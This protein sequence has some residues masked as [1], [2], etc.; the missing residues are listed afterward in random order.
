MR[1]GRARLLPPGRSRFYPVNPFAL[2]FLTGSSTRIPVVGLGGYRPSYL[3]CALRFFSRALGRGCQLRSR[4]RLGGP[5]Q[6]A[7]GGAEFLLVVRIPAAR[8][9]GFGGEHRR[10]T[11]CLG[12]ARSQSRVLKVSRQR[13][14][15]HHRVWHAKQLAGARLVR[16]K[17]RHTEKHRQEASEKLYL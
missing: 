2:L 8:T 4:R 16:S 10:P 17:S 9:P 15:D 12:L 13:D 14:C 1:S 3:S 7:L 11:Q 5:T 6:S